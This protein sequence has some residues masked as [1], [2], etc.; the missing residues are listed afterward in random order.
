MNI[1][2]IKEF[3]LN[4]LEEIKNII[5]EVNNWN[6]SLVGFEVFDNNEYFFNDIFYGS[7]YELVEKLNATA[8]ENLAKAMKEVGGLLVHISID[9]VFEAELY[10]TS[11]KEDQ[12]STPTGVYG[13]TKLLGEQ[14]I[15]SML[16]SEASPFKGDSREVLHYY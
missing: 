8:P 16:G 14:K 13:Q 6:G 15:I 4:N 2:K 9:Y 1:E 5:E 12:T 10:N 7:K 3:L 11:C